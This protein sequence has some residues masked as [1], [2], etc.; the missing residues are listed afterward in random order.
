MTELLGVRE[1]VDW[2]LCAQSEEEDKEDAA[3]FKAAYAP[4]D[5]SA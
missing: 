5:L 1:R 2:K 4:F 3:A